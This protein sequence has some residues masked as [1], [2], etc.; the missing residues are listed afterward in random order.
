MKKTL[1]RDAARIAIG[2][3]AKHPQ[4]DYYPHFT[5]IV[6][7]NKMVCWGTN[8]EGIPPIHLGYNERISFGKPKI[9]SEYNAYRKAR[10]ILQPNNSFEVINIRLNRNGEMRQS[11][12]CSCC[13][14]FLSAVGCSS[15]YFSTKIG[16]DEIKMV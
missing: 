14:N 12:P 2:K 16:W 8:N 11:M 6:Q 4:F 15:C 10:G 5:F 9:H 1:L 13:Y 3:L 7:N